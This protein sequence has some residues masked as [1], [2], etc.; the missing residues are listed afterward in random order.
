LGKLPGKILNWNFDLRGDGV[1]G[2][3]Y[4]AIMETQMTKFQSYTA[5]WSEHRHRI[6]FI[7][8]VLEQFPEMDDADGEILAD[9]L[10]SLTQGH[11]LSSE[12]ENACRWWDA[13]I[14]RHHQGR[15][16]SIIGFSLAVR[17]LPVVVHDELMEARQRLRRGEDMTPR[18]AAFWGN[19]VLKRWN[20]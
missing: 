8:Y 14:K 16:A 18:Q 3:G 1:L 11:D 7:H 10:A 20:A 19:H 6:K 4:H 13:W 17:D 2:S 15:F 12:Q 9:C 5:G